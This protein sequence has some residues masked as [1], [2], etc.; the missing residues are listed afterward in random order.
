[1]KRR[2]D[3]GV[4]WLA[5]LGAAVMIF[6]FSCQNG[7]ESLHTSG[8]VV[9]WIIGM[10]DPGFDQR[11]AAEQEAWW[12]T[13]SL[14]VRKGAH[15]S[16]YA[17]LGALLCLLYRSYGRAHGELLAWLT[18]TAY[19][20]TDEMHQLLVAARSGSAVDVGIDGAGAL[21]GVLV[22]VGIEA[23]WRRARGESGGDDVK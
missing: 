22:A 10:I 12:E 18:A 3:R 20:G 1:M 21:F 13:C 15:F 4:L 9:N 17:L 19:A 2:W 11:P 5:V 6:L 14:V 16:E 8:R 23:L 7:D